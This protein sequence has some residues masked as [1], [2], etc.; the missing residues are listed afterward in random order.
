[1]TVIL[2]YSMMIRIMIDEKRLRF[3]FYYSNQHW[4]TQDNR[5]L[6]RKS[7]LSIAIVIENVTMQ[8]DARRTKMHD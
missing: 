4:M 6:T 5:H 2:G 1:M 8:H 7:E 3:E